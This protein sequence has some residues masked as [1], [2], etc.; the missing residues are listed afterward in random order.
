MRI[1]RPPRVHGG[2]LAEEMGLGKTCE[3]LALVLRD[4]ELRYP[5]RLP[6]SETTT[7]R[8]NGTLVVVPVT[9]LAQWEAEIAK[10]V[11][12]GLLR[13]ATY[14]GETQIRKWQTKAEK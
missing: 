7:Q 5:H 9:L 2:L 11:E 14:H 13:I 8:S 10:T 3:L 4:R 12:P 6:P 1:D